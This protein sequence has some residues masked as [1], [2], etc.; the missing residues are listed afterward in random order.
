MALSG[1]TL[2]VGAPGKNADAGAAYL[3][4]RSG[5]TWGEHAIFSDQSRFGAGVAMG[6]GVGM[7]INRYRVTTIVRSGLS[8]SVQQ[9]LYPENQFPTLPIRSITMKGD[10]ALVGMPEY[11]H[12]GIPNVGAAYVLQHVAA[13]STTT[14]RAKLMAPAAQEND[15][16]GSSVAF[17]GAHAL[18]GAEAFLGEGF[19][20]GTRAAYYL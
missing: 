17:D 2:I 20:N 15:F 5:A 10:T 8:W 6:E 13:S 3:F 1:G 11:P 7:I 12:T 18:I 14:V 19:V 16:F 9:V 4:I